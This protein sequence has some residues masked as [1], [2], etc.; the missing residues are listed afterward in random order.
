MEFE[1]VPARD[2]LDDKVNRVF[3]GKVVRKD[4]VRKVKVG[5]NVPVFV[6]EY[7]LGKYCASSDEMA[8]QMGLQVVNDTLAENYI[9]PDEATKAQSKVKEQGTF[10]FID[11]VKVR[12]TDSNYWAEVVNFGHRYVHIP[13]N[14]IRDFD[15]LLTGGIWAQIDMQF[16]YDEETRGK[17]P[18]WIRK[19]TPIQLATFDLEEY[20]RLRAE[21]TTDEWVDFLIR[22]MGYEPGVMDRRL[23]LMFLLRLIPLCERNYNLIELGPRG[24]G[25]SYAIQELSPYAALLTGPTT[26]PNLFGHM[27]GKQKGMVMIWD[28]VG[29][30]EVGNPENAKRAFHRPLRLRGGLPGRSTPGAPQIQLHGNH[31]PL[32]L[33]RLTPECPGPQGCSADRFRTHEDP[34]PTW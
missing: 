14:Y 22:S 9:R 4:L 1:N 2:A 30:D 19:L 15:R 21:F 32:L 8:I 5:A 31:R 12:L 34:A 29:F 28:V 3:A 13:D 11:K 25:K 24:T 20:R 6:L 7:L 16:E 17:N 26:V 33:A 27:S 10:T 23:K 18:F